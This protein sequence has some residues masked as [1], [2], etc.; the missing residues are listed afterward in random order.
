L[1]VAA[2]ATM[3]LVGCS[4]GGGLGPDRAPAVFGEGPVTLAFLVVGPE[5]VTVRLDWIGG[6]GL[7]RSRTHVVTRERPIDLR[8]DAMP[9][10]DI[11]VESRACPVPDNDGS[12]AR[13]KDP[14]VIGDGPVTLAF[15]MI[16][17]APVRTRVAWLDGGG[18]TIFRTLTVTADRPIHLRVDQDLRYEITLDRNC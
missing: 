9:V 2:V 18:A 7:P 16:A 6:D 13:V 11:T 10:Y 3:M 12:E 5:P 15:G 17:G 1:A 8:T 14:L 4:S